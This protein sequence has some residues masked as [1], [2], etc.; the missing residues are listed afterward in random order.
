MFRKILAT[1]LPKFSIRVE[2]PALDYSKIPTPKDNSEEI[3]KMGEKVE[4][5]DSETTKQ[6]SKIEASL[7]KLESAVS[8]NT[9]AVNSAPK[10]QKIEKTHFLD[11]RS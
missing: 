3:R 2:D 9:K 8:A 4:K 10:V 11:P 5:K 1:E 6:L 7:T